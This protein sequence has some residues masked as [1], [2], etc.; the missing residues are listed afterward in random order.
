MANRLTFVGLD[1][2]VK[3]LQALPGHLRDEAKTIIHASATEAKA[4]MQAAY[5]EGPRG[6]LKRGLSVTMRD[7]AFGAAGIVK[8]SSPHAFIFESGTQARYVNT[9]PLSRAKNFGYR[10]GAMPPGRVFIPIAMRRRREMYAG[11]MDVVRKQGFQVS[12]HAG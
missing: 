11:L 8:N 2:L 4:E 9:L 1:Q 3:D 12:G 10:R 5:P 7:D 6:K